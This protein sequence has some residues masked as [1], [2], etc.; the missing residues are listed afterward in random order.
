MTFYR[1]RFS[2]ALDTELD[3]CNDS[4]TSEQYLYTTEI[5]EI[6]SPPSQWQEHLQCLLSQ[7][8]GDCRRP[9][10]TPGELN[11]TGEG[12]STL[13]QITLCS[14]MRCTLSFMLAWPKPNA[15]PLGDYDNRWIIKLLDVHNSHTFPFTVRWSGRIIHRCH[16]RHSTLNKQLRRAE[17]CGSVCHCNHNNITKKT[18]Q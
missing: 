3:I 10:V 4:S 8:G 13:S 9:V 7:H 16:C 14:F 1:C 15:A 2:F 18:L 11:W 12:L 5:A 17:R 6:I